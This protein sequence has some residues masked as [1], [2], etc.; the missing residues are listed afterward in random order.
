MPVT[1]SACQETPRP[2][3]HHRE[4]ERDGERLRFG[5]VLPISACHHLQ[6]NVPI[7]LA[8][9]LLSLVYY[10]SLS[11][12]RIGILELPF[13]EHVKNR[14]HFLLSGDISLPVQSRHSQLEMKRFKIRDY[15]LKHSPYLTSPM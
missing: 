1:D 13:C 5:I 4:R 3:P 10:L 2:P 6:C 15:H 14:T 9:A 11:R 12:T 7:T 8:S